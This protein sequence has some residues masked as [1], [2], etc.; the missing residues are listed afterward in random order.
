VRRRLAIWVAAMGLTAIVGCKGTETGPVAGELSVRLTTPRNTDRAVAFVLI[1][2]QHGATA[3]AGSPYRLFTATSAAGDTTRIVV[4]APKGSG[5][6]AGEVA[7]ISV[8]DVRRAA[9]YIASLTDVAA[10][11]YSVGAT[12]GLSLTVVKP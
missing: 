8:D 12:T 3:A 6:G 1:G 5:I 4:M 11:D 7:R 2:K 10:A 9:S